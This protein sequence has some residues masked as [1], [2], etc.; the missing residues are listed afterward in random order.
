[1]VLCFNLHVLIPPSQVFLTQGLGAG[2]G[3]GLTYVP[4]VAIISQYFQRKRALAMTIVASGASIG[5]VIHPIML[6][7]LLGTRLGFGNSVRAS[8]GLV[9]GL[10]LIGCC[11]MRTRIPVQA[12]HVQQRQILAKLAKDKAYI[13]AALG[14]APFSSC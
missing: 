10:L 3:G 11:L 5:A 12:K 6:N 8:A 2:L 9:A 14:C 1:M 4:S 13:A 7:H